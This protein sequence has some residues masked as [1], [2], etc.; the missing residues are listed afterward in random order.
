MEL[1]PK[2][3]LQS[4]FCLLDNKKDVDSIRLSCRKFRAICVEY[5]SIWSK[6]IVELKYHGQ[7]G[8]VPTARVCQSGKVITVS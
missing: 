1:L 3:I 4:I 7:D 2:D 5:P 8:N 6:Y